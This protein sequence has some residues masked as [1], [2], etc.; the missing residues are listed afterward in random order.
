MLLR[1]R[2]FAGNSRTILILACIAIAAGGLVLAQQNPGA[3]VSKD[4]S[5]AEPPKPQPIPFSH[6]LHSHFFPDCLAC[7]QLAA[8]GWA[9]FRLRVRAEIRADARSI[10]R[11]GY[12][13]QNFTSAS[14]C[15]RVA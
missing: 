12:F 4:G 7:H 14:F 1:T 15:F 6:K 5:K 13:Q 9:I 2:Q 11:A 8:D 3:D 10:N